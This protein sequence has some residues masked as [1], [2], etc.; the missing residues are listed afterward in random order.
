MLTFQQVNAL[1]QSLDNT[2]ARSGG[3]NITHSLQDN[4]LVLRYSTIVHFASERALSQQMRALEEES[5]QIL[6]DKVKAVKKQFRELTDSALKLREVLNRDNV[7]LVQ[8]TSITPRKIAY[9]R[10]VVEFEVEN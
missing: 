8:A 1:G 6:N 10:R 5:H 4:R 9:Y 3:R 2:W 7:E